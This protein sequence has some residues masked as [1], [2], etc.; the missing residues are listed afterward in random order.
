[1][2]PSGDKLSETSV[3]YSFEGS[4]RD[5]PDIWTLGTHFEMSMLSSYSL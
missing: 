5:R 2:A 4:V 3:T 1:M